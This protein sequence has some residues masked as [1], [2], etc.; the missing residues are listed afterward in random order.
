MASVKKKSVSFYQLIKNNGRFR[1]LSLTAIGVHTT[2]E[3]NRQSEKVGSIPKI[4]YTRTWVLFLCICFCVSIVLC[5]VD[6]ARANSI[7]KDLKKIEWHRSRKR[8]EERKTVNTH[9]TFICIDNKSALWINSLS[10]CTDRANATHK[11]LEHLRATHRAQSEKPK[12][13]AV[14][15]KCQKEIYKMKNPIVLF[16]FSIL[17]R[18]KLEHRIKTLDNRFVIT[19]VSIVHTWNINGTLC[20]VRRF[21]AIRMNLDEE[22]SDV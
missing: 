11:M 20:V 1:W 19:L 21:R 14:E 9:D 10:T 5:D 22:A 8:N 3:R 18:L 17:L 12:K 15:I 2:L 16:S 13:K 4:V 6:A 7:R